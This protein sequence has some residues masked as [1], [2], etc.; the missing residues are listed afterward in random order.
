MKLLNH[1][2]VTIL[3]IQSEIW[4]S[5]MEGSSSLLHQPTSNY[6]GLILHST[7]ILAILSH[8]PWH[9]RLA[10]RQV[11]VYHFQRF[12]LFL[13]NVSKYP[14]LSESLF[15]IIYP[16]MGCVWWRKSSVLCIYRAV[17]Y[18]YWSIMLVIQYWNIP[19][20]RCV[21]WCEYV[22]VYAGILIVLCLCFESESSD[23]FLNVVFECLK[24]RDII[25]TLST[26]LFVN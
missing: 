19:W 15:S 23:V 20:W 16:C 10:Q 11:T 7:F 12:A 22:H 1:V 2:Q 14:Q 5:I 18:N 21:W 4:Q 9:L 8:I 26:W 13:C 25:K 3:S 24:C 6:T 17:L